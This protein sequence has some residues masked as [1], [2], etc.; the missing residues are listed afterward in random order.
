VTS[1]DAPA[2]YPVTSMS[3]RDRQRRTYEAEWDT[4]TSAKINQPISLQNARAMVRRHLPGWTVV[5]THDS[6]NA[7]CYCEVKRIE[8]GSLSPA[9]IVAHEI[10]HGLVD[11]SGAPPGHHDVFR[12]HYVDVVG[13]EV[14]RYWSRKLAGQFTQ[15]S[16]GMRLPDERRTP[17]LVVLALRL[18]GRL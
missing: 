10:A 8:I 12:R 11:L 1:R 4:F 14:G 6:S 5:R 9:W 17:R 7:W 13:E 15:R 18:L 16:L 3:Y 2:N